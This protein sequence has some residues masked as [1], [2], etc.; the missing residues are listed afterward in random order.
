LSLQTLNLDTGLEAGPAGYTHGKSAQR[1]RPRIRWRDYIANLAWSSV[2]PAELS[3]AV[4]RHEVFSA[5]L[6]LLP[7]RPS[8]DEKVLNGMF[9]QV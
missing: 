8:P 3:E 7:P 9:E 5:L 6:R 2:E 4:E 1:G